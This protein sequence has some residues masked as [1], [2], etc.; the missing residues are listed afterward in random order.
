[1]VSR[2]FAAA[3]HMGDQ[4]TVK[5]I[6]QLVLLWAVWGGAG[7][8]C[9]TPQKVLPEDASAV[10]E[11]RPRLTWRIVDG[12][13]GY[14]VRMQSRVPEG[15]VIA[16][17]DTV[18]KTPTYLPPQPL[19]DRHSKVTMRVNAIC[20]KETSAETVSWFLIDTTANCRLGEVKGSTAASLA[21]EAVE[22]ARNYEVRAH[23]L[24]DGLLLASLETRT[25]AAKLELREAAV[26]SVRPACAGGSGEAVYRVLA[27]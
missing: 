4:V 11:G 20:G 9:D 5:R 3:W 26:V 25:P 19:A 14:R 12:A 23:R 6:L 13:T 10:T 7:L 2:I 1:M 16:A 15:R 27:R 24:S 17:A 21:W 18:V 8:A 22:G